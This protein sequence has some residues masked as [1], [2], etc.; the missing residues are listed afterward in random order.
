[1]TSLFKEIR[2][3]IPPLSQNNRASKQPFISNAVYTTQYCIQKEVTIYNDY[4][5]DYD[6]KLFDSEFKAE[7]FDDDARG[8][9]Y[10]Y[11]D[12]GLI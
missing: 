6:T 9:I 8:Y 4:G 11:I 5:S 1:M 10:I 2:F 3:K 7:D 12:M